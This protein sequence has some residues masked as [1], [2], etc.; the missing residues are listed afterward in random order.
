M[1]QRV[2]TLVAQFAEVNKAIRLV[3]AS[4]TEAQWQTPCS[5]ERW[6]VGVTVHHV[7]NGY[8]QEGWV[9]GV[10]AAILAGQALPAHPAELH[11][12]RDYNEWNAQHFAACSQD[13][14]LA[15]LRRNET[16]A[17]RLIESLQ[18]EDLD[19]TAPASS[20][21]D[22]VSVQQIIENILID[23]AQEHLSSLRATLERG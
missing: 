9:A 18:D 3:V 8:D 5:S 13:E 15:L 20:D 14:T 16:A 4:C 21:G 7:A 23:H 11:P 2:Q 22:M 19:K 17:L 10:I 1:G 6:S 12:D